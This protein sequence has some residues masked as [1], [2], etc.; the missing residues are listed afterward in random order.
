[1]SN[2]STITHLLNLLLGACTATT[3]EDQREISTRMDEFNTS[4]LCN[5]YLLSVVLYIPYSQ[6]TIPSNLLNSIPQSLL[7]TIQGMASLILKNNLSRRRIDDETIQ[8][9]KNNL[10][11]IINSIT[12]TPFRLLRSTI[13]SLLAMVIRRITPSITM[14]SLL[15]ALFLHKE[16]LPIA[17]AIRMICEDAQASLLKDPSS[18]IEAIILPGLLNLLHLSNV[19]IKVEALRALTTFLK[20]PSAFLFRAPDHRV[21]IDVLM[22]TLSS[23]ALLVFENPMEKELHLA[24]CECAHILLEG[25]ILQIGDHDTDEYIG[26]LMPFILRSMKI[27]N[28]DNYSL[29]QLELRIALEASEFFLK[30]LSTQEDRVIDLLEERGEFQ[31]LISILLGNIPFL[32]DDAEIE[33]VLAEEEEE[34]EISPQGRTIKNDSSKKKEEGEDDEDGIENGEILNGQEEEGLWTLRKCSAASMDALS[35]ILGN[36]G[37]LDVFNHILESLY[38]MSQSVDWRSREASYLIIGAIAPGIALLPL[39]DQLDLSPWLEILLNSITISCDFGQMMISSI[40]C[41]SVSRLLPIIIE[42]PKDGCV[43]NGKER[44]ET[45]IYKLSSMLDLTFSNSRRV[46]EAALSS[47]WAILNKGGSIV[48]DGKEILSLL[49][50]ML[51]G[52]F[53]LSDRMIMLSKS[54]LSVVI[55]F[56]TKKDH[57]LELQQL[58]MLV[59]SLFNQRI[60]HWICLKPFK[61]DYILFSFSESLSCFCGLVS[62]GVEVWAPSYEMIKYAFTKWQAELSNENDYMDDTDWDYAI[63]SIDLI[64]SSLRDMRRSGGGGGSAIVLESK[65]AALL[66]MIAQIISLFASSSISDVRQCVFAFVG[67]LYTSRVMMLDRKFIYEKVL[68]DGLVGPL[69]G[70]SSIGNGISNAASIANAAWALG[71][72]VSWGKELGTVDDFSTSLINSLSS[73]LSI[74]DF[75][76]LED[77]RRSLE[78]GRVLENVAIAIGKGIGPSFSDTTMKMNNWFYL[79]SDVLEYDGIQNDVEKY[80]SIIGMFEYLSSERGKLLHYLSREKEL[81]ARIFDVFH[82]LGK[83]DDRLIHYISIITSCIREVDKRHLL[84][85]L[86]SIYPNQT[87][88]LISKKLYENLSLQF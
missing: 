4:P 75:Y 57:H 9:L 80:Q 6:E 85:I 66:K 73:I 51:Q 11:L 27:S 43:I 78:D 26:A 53:T 12:T 83:C 69:N 22:S 17:E 34:E 88:T 32:P 15:P 79:M 44:I 3:S 39:K 61:H 42:S 8:A 64:G 52:T 37:R 68:M 70:D 16:S 72:V 87:A 71:E 46:R 28:E 20:G 23:L 40:S 36:S 48:V 86:S 59:L 76:K 33:L 31:S 24:I 54:I 77:I 13:G 67:D 55:Y 60:S 41:W 49:L 45:V 58:Y 38:L 35:I 18:P 65:D 84:E 5:V 30:I 19:P 74:S 29:L 14:P 7:S 50:K 56:V 10:P 25:D 1:M 47:I 2:Q 63:V 62:I 82:L 81:G 21:N